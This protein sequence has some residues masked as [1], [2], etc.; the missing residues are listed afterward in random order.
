MTDT[1]AEHYAHLLRAYQYQLGLGHVDRRLEL[2][3]RLV[4]T[5][6]PEA[7][8]IVRLLEQTRTLDGAVCELGVAQ[9]ATSALI[10]NELLDRSASDLHLFD[11]FLGLSKPTS[12]DV[13]LDDVFN[14]GS[15]AAYAGKMACPVEMVARRLDDVGFPPSRVTI[16]AGFLD[17][18]L[19]DPS[20]LPGKVRFAYL[21]VDLYEPTRLALSWLDKVA[22]TGTAIIV[23]DYGFF[24]EGVRTAVDDFAQARL[25]H[26]MKLV[27]HSAIGHFCTLVRM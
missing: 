19:V 27:A 23:D 25:G 12:E 3:A 26:W 8:E 17:K 9:G 1:T 18:T 6:P 11:S 22:V 5:K 20:R 7:F 15:M 10:A 2:V 14:L 24:S 16:H 21:D 13:L 4:G